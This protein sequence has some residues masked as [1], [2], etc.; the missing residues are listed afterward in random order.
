MLFRSSYD[1]EYI[2]FVKTIKSDH[3]KSG[4]FIHSGFKNSENYFSFSNILSIRPYS[5]ASFADKK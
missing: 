3:S 5:K 4:F 2:I 1:I